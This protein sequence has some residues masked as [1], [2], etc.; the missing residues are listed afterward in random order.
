MTVT[1]GEI[2]KVLKRV[3][4][5]RTSDIAIKYLASQILGF[6]NTLQMAEKYPDGFDLE[7]AL[8]LISDAVI[9]IKKYVIKDRGSQFSFPS[10]V[11]W[12]FTFFS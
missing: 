2:H 6:L 9:L 4:A 8:Y 7:Q 1:L 11:A 10:N 5:Q 12:K 3:K